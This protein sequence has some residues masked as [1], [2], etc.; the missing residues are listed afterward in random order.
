[1]VCST[2]SL[3][4]TVRLICRR[5]RTG[6]KG[7]F[8]CYYIHAEPGNCFVGCGLYHPEND[9]IHKLRESIDERPRRW[10][11][12]LNDPALKKQFL[13]SAAKN[14]KPEAA[15]KAFADRNQDNALKTKPK[16]TRNLRVHLCCRRN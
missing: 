4:R 9:A 5:S 16:V 6:R 8:A 12:I 3:L 2:A 10:R 1:M 13:P 15:L 11:R 14:S 7:P